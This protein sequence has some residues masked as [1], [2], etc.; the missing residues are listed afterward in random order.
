M[1]KSEGNSK[2]KRGQERG[3]ES[4]VVK[5]K[6]MAKTREIAIIRAYNGNS[7]TEGKIAGISDG[8]SESIS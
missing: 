4:A 8:K 5:A 3:Q 6:E 2:S 7:K 1:G